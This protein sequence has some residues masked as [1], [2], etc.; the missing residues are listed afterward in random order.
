MFVVWYMIVGESKTA[1]M[2]CMFASLVP[3]FPTPPPPT[4][5]AEASSSKVSFVEATPIIPYSSGEKMP[6]DITEYLFRLLL[7]Y[8]VSQV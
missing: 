3:G 4:N 6:E 8:M 7:D 2:D 5:A 1:E